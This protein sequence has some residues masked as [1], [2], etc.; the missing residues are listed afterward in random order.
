MQKTKQ[1]TKQKKEIVILT[2][3][4]R[5]E[6][7]TNLFKN[8]KDKEFTQRQ[9]FETLYGKIENYSEMRLFYMWIKV[10]KDL[11]SLRRYTNCFVASRRLESGGY[12]YFLVTNQYQANFYINRMKN[13]KRRCDIMS[14]KCQKIVDKKLWQK[15]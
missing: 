4:E 1:Q 10:L 3:S 7:L 15:I 9:I 5:R 6:K 12:R 14:K 8:N 13:I 11:N 2:A